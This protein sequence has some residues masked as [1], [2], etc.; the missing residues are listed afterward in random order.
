MREKE[1]KE[2]DRRRGKRGVVAM[3]QWDL[4]QSHSICLSAERQGR[5][6]VNHPFS[7]LYSC[8]PYQTPSFGTEASFMLG[9]PWSYRL[10]LE[11]RTSKKKSG[12]G[13]MMSLS[14]MWKV[15][16]AHKPPGFHCIHLDYAVGL[17]N[18]FGQPNATTS[19]I[20]RLCDES[21]PP[22]HSWLQACTWCQHHHQGCWWYNSEWPYQGQPWVSL[23]GGGGEPGWRLKPKLGCWWRRPRSP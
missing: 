7:C 1:R 10:L 2:R 16:V 5:W 13:N 15:H 22:P 20:A 3:P 14:H 11:W 21:F 12:S 4:L 18:L 6:A 9:Q 17:R 8:I 19:R 23:Q